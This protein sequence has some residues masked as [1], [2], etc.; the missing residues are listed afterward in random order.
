MKLAILQNPDVIEKIQYRIQIQRPKISEDL[1]VSSNGI[2][3]NAEIIVAPQS[4]LLV[5]FSRVI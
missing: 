2:M 5:L 4:S 1:L 3:A